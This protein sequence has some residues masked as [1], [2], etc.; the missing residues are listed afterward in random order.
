MTLR[1]RKILEAFEKPPPGL[2]FRFPLI[3]LARKQNGIYRTSFC[4]P[5]GGQHKQFS[6]KQCLNTIVALSCYRA[7]KVEH[8]CKFTEWCKLVT[9]YAI[10]LGEMFLLKAN[11]MLT[12]KHELPAKIMH[13]TLR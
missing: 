4:L 10:M 3:T 2:G 11:I 8:V 7:H 12:S 6:R 1:T 5:K 13:K 9:E